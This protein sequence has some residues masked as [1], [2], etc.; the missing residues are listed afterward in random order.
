M[1]ERRILFVDDEPYVLKGFRRNFRNLRKEF[2]LFYVE[3]AFEG[4]ALSKEMEFDVVISD[5]KMPQMDGTT[6]LTEIQKK[7]PHTIRIML[8]AQSE[9]LSPLSLVGVVHQYLIKPCN[10]EK[11]KSAILQASALH[12]L[13]KLNEPKDII[14]CINSLPLQKKTYE[15][16]QEKLKQPSFYLNSQEKST[17]AELSVATK[18]LRMLNSQLSQN[19]KKIN[20]LNEAVHILGENIVRDLAMSV[21]LFSE[22]EKSTGVS[23]PEVFVYHSITVGALAKK[24]AEIHSTEK[25][26]IYKSFIAGVLHDIGKIVINSKLNT[27]IKTCNTSTGPVRKGLSESIH[28]NLGAFLTGLWGFPS[29]IIE[30]VGFHHNLED[31][32]SSPFNPALSVYVANAL[33]NHFWW[34]GDAGSSPGVDRKDFQKRDLGDN[35]KK[36]SRL[37]Y[38]YLDD[39]FN[40]SKIQRPEYYVP[41]CSCEGRKKTC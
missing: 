7:S 17:D 1:E 16:F 27:L 2:A 30:A 3:S 26:V 29:D 32:S 41:F 14:S 9:M 15:N 31:N 40:G 33:Y 13:M 23:I 18:I 28:S 36:W 34:N 19:D 12:R 37:C 35:L 22:A 38:S 4:L 6:F 24:I 8:T 25:E 10:P 21:Q 5:L 39:L 20:S 11:L